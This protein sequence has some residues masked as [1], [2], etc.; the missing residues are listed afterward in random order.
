MISISARPGATAWIKY[1][2]CRDTCECDLFNL[3]IINQVWA[4]DFGLWISDFKGI[5]QAEIRT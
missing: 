3:A 5:E 1:T 2:D 4:R